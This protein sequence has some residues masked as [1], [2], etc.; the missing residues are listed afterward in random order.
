M[1]RFQQKKFVSCRFCGEILFKRRET[2][3]KCPFCHG[4]KPGLIAFPEED[5]RFFLKRYRRNPKLIYKFS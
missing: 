4:E 2:P 1:Q 3:T 5:L